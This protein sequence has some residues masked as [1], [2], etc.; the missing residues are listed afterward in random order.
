FRASRDGAA[1][2]AALAALAGDARQDRNLMPGI[3]AAVCA[4]ATLGEVVSA[5]KS[6]FGE[7]SLGRQGGLKSSK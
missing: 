5:L 2:S 3:L 6:V 7:H 4:R 1:A